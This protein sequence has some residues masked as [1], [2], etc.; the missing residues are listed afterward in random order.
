MEKEAS[1]VWADKLTISIIVNHKKYL[2]L[3]EFIES[4][5][6]VFW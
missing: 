2:I 3:K 6:D 1:L 5:V 4:G